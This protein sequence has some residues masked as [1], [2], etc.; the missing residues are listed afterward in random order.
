MVSK[1]RICTKC[2]NKF[3]LSN[4]YKSKLKGVKKFKIASV[5]K[6]CNIIAV[7]ENQQLKAE[8]YAIWLKKH[9]LKPEVQQ[10]RKAYRDSAKGKAVRAEAYKF[11]KSDPKNVE[12]KRLRQRERYRRLKL[13]AIKG[14]AK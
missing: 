13:E 9:L 6:I 11:W 1:V 4:F 8:Y 3:P 10:R 5:C 2:K 7:R 14:E 12:R